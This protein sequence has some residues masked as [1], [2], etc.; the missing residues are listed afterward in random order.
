M[1]ALTFESNNKKF[2]INKQTYN[3]LYS[4]YFYTTHHVIKWWLEIHRTFDIST[5]FSMNIESEF[6]ELL[7]KSD[8][9]EYEQINE[10]DYVFKLNN[11]AKLQ[12]L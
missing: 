9:F 7:I 5:S 6:I 8:L 11:V 3:E 2:K 4:I 1:K 12:L 10:I